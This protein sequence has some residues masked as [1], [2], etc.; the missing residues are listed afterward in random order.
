MS[1]RSDDDKGEERLSSHMP[2]VHGKVRASEWSPGLEWVSRATREA[3]LEHR[4]NER[5]DGSS[6]GSWKTCP[7]EVENQ[8]GSKCLKSA[9]S[10]HVGLF[11]ESLAN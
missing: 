5:R 8:G 9:P 10:L 3:V 11:F 7:E 4:N 6:A 2:K 1:S